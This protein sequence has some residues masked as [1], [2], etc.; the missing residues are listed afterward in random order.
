MAWNPH[1]VKITAADVGAVGDVTELAGCIG[2]NHA[3]D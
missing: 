1:G 3:A 2:K